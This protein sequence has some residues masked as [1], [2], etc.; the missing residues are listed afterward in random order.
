MKQTTPSAAVA[1]WADFLLRTRFNSH[2]TMPLKPPEAM[3]ISTIVKMGG[4]K[5]KTKRL[6]ESDKVLAG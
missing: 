4:I 2:R 5:D 3:M 6:V 1:I